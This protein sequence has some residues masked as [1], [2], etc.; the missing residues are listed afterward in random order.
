MRVNFDLPDN[1]KKARAMRKWFQHLEESGDLCVY[2]EAWFENETA[3]VESTLE[4]WP[5]I[6]TEDDLSYDL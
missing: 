2:M 3:E 6:L 4:K 1:K 5:G